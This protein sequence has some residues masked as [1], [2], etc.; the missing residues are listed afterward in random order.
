[1]IEVRAATQSDLEEINDVYNHYVRT[2]PATFDI[3]E[4]SIDARRDWFE[5]FGESGPYRIFVACEGNEVVGFAY[6][7]PLHERKAYETSLN[8]TVYV[9]PDRRTKGIGKALYGTLFEAIAGEDVHRAYAGISMPNPASVGL[10]ESFGFR[11]VALFSEQGRKFDRYWDV[12]WL[13][14]EL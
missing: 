7:S 12:A 1:M 10:H 14:K 3:D 6:S 2:S 11:Q 13:E 8:V 5:Q 9:A 4:V